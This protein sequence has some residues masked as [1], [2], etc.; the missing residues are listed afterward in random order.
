MISKIVVATTLALFSTDA[1]TSKVDKFK[2]DLYCLAA[3]LYFEARGESI[4]GQ[5]AV[6][7]V[8]LNRVKAN[9][10]P[11]SVCNV[12]FQRKKFTWVAQET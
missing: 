12:V 6:A 4:K 1:Y 10:Y 9:Q 8:T 2:Q 7:E 5:I 11:N 3:N